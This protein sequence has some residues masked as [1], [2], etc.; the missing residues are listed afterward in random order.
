MALG[1]LARLFLH[2]K[3]SVIPFKDDDLI[4][5]YVKDRE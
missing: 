2:V 4:L 3:S 5:S 1:P